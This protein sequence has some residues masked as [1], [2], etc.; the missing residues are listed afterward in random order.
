M[1]PHCDV[2]ILLVTGWICNI[3]GAWTSSNITMSTV[4][5]DIF[6]GYDKKLSPKYDHAASD[7]QVVVTVNIFINSMFSVSEA[8]MDYSMSMFLRERWVDE[9]L[10]YV[11][12]QN[13]TRLELDYSLFD[14]VWMPDMFILNEKFSNFHEVT[15][16]NKMVHVY[17]D[18]TVQYSARVTGT[19]FCKMNLRKY[20]FDTQSCHFEVESY[21]HST[22]TMKFVWSEDAVTIADSIEFPQFELIETQSYSCEK[23]YFGI[24]FPCIGVNIIL[25]RNYAYYIIQ[26]YIPS[27]LIVILSWVNFWLDPTSVPARI[28]LGL[29]TVLTMT[30]QSAGARAN[31]PRVSLLTSTWRRV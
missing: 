21:G 27:V 8:N 10:R 6:D 9:R 11:D 29:L 17:P 5:G 26:I 19:F 4:L 23:D 20:P 25:K 28:S 24:V 13:F 16:P 15:I 30:T 3:P 14:Q 2:R 12:D 18:G 1:K 22:S 31:L 7:R